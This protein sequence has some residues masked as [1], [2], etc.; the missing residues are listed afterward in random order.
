MM[1]KTPVIFFGIC[2]AW[3]LAV[4]L[5][6][7]QVTITG[8]IPGGESIDLR[9]MTSDDYITS[10]QKILSQIITGPHGEFVF[11]LEPE[12][13]MEVYLETGYYS[14]SFFVEM[15]GNYILHCD[16]IDSRKEQRP[17]YNKEPL[18]AYVAEEPIPRLNEL[19]NGFNQTYNEF[20]M[21]EFGGIYQKRNT[22][23][24]NGFR[25][26]VEKEY[27]NYD[28]P[29][30]QDYMNYRLAGVELAM[31]PSKKPLLFRD[32]LSNKPV[33]LYHPEYMD[34]FNDFFDKY[35]YPDNRFIK[36]EDL[37]STINR[38]PDYKA[39]L[40]SLGKDTILRNEV[41]RELVCLKTMKQ[42]YYSS[43][44]SK[45]SVLEII[46]QIGQ[47]SKFQAHCVIA[48]N[49]A[50]ELTHLEKGYPAPGFELPGLHGNQI[51]LSDYRGKPV[52]LSFITS[53][54]SACLKELDLMKDMHQQYKSRISFLS[55]SF[56][57]DIPTVTGLAQ[58]RGY[59]W[60]FVVNGLDY[61]LISD[62]RIMTF[63]VFILLDGNGR[64]IEYPAYKPSEII[65][66]S[67]D[68]ITV[69]EK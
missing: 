9:L 38:K 69:Q 42:L 67:F 17:F 1:L 46:N 37:Y 54:S 50:A 47:F 11:S 20:I 29:F 40:D 7:Q 51:R 18:P 15:E 10:R 24:L 12:T 30:F 39:L 55:V 53:W 56:D 26:Q 31:A 3:L 58:E 2:I 43:D 6:G 16:S 28:H 65:R 44:F 23:I 33:L 8:V 63:P 59:D 4:P 21:R 57:Q 68:R 34:F 35:L 32:F 27:R 14:F 60:D 48:F 41:I 13:I 62:Y 66:E 49:L 45:T 52:Y 19:I 22:A 25:E 61:P 36:R 64:I 5:N